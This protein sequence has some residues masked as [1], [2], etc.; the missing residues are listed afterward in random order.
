V[1]AATSST[2]RRSLRLRVGGVGFSSVME[3]VLSWRGMG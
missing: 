2:H 3:R 1:R